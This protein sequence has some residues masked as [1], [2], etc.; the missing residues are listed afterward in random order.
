[1]RKVLTQHVIPAGAA[2]AGGGGDNLLMDFMSGKLTADDA[3]RRFD[4]KLLTPAQPDPNYIFFE[5]KPRLARDKQDFETIKLVLISPEIEKKNQHL[6]Y[7]P[8]MIVMASTNNEK[9]ETW[10]FPNPQP[11]VKGY[12][13]EHFKPVDPGKDWQKVM[14]N[15]P[16]GGPGQPRVV[17]P[18]GPGK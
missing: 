8:R 10:S 14:G 3:F 9:I 7:L 15:P 6:A 2:G 17:R 13:L 12:T 5:I 4:I 16:A 1:L 18:T 11:N